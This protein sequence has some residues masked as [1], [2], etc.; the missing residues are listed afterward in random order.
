MKIDISLRSNQLKYINDKVI[1]DNICMYSINSLLQ[2][3]LSTILGDGKYSLRLKIR[4]YY[5]AN[6]L[7]NNFIDKFGKENLIKLKNT[8]SV[9]NKDDLVEELNV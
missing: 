5:D 2:S 6:F 4:D 9:L 1:I 8:L 3:K 7:I